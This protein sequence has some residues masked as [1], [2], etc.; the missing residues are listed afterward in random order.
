MRNFVLPILTVVIAL[1]MFTGQALACPTCGK[2]REVL[3]PSQTSNLAGGFDASIY[4]LLGTVVTA[5][6]FLGW[7]LFKSSSTPASKAD[8]RQ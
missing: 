7:T 2:A 3:P 1:A 5:M 8:E 6:G 4:V